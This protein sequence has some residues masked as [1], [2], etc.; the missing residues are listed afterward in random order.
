MAAIRTDVFV[1]ADHNYAVR[2]QHCTLG[3]G[4]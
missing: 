1:P 3:V 4:T 2:A